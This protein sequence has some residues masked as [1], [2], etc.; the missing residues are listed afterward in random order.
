MP[1]PFH[2]LQSE[3]L[4]LFQRLCVAEEDKMGYLNS[5]VKIWGHSFPTG[6]CMVKGLNKI[7]KVCIFISAD[8]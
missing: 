8:S 4:H 6:A 2:E 7:L 1:K 5:I 3:L